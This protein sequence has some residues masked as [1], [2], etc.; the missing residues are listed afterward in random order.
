MPILLANLRNS[1]KLLFNQAA[2]QVIRHRLQQ[3]VGLGTA[4]F[5]IQRIALER[6]KLLPVKQQAVHM[7]STI[8]Q[9]FNPVAI[10]TGSADA[11]VEFVVLVVPDRGALLGMERALIVLMLTHQIANG[12]VEPLQPGVFVLRFGQL[13]IGV[14]GEG[15]DLL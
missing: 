12:V 2:S 9:P 5:L 8:G 10:G 3:A 1:A 7:A 11:L 14:V 6:N 15:L 13:A 4:S